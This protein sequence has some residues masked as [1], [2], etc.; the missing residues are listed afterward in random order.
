MHLRNEIEMQ[1][2]REMRDITH[3][4]L[5]KREFKSEGNALDK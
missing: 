2:R 3:T 4:H 5:M 1:I